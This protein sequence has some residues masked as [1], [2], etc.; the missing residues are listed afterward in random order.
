MLDILRGGATVQVALDRG[1]GQPYIPGQSVRAR[2]TVEC[3]RD[4][5]VREGRVALVYH[6]EY[7]YRH[8]ERGRDSQGHYHTSTHSTWATVEQE[9]VR[10]VFVH[11]GTIPAGSANAYEF[12]LPLPAEAAP[13]ARTPILRVQW[14]VK[15]TLDRRL[16]M[17]A[18]GKA[19]LPVISVAPAGAAPDAYYGASGEADQAELSFYLPGKVWALGEALTGQLVVRPRQEFDVTE[20]RVELVQRQMVPRALGNE[21]SEATPARVSDALRLTPGQDFS[22]PFS[23]VIP[24]AGPPSLAT[25]N[26]RS[27]WFLRGVLARRL[28]KDTAVEEEISICSARQ[29]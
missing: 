11:E 22:L 15:A 10:Q 23:L 18:E 16:A 25:P 5:T 27:Q 19:E 1:P 2:V 17:D 29:S 20:I 12:D 9:V 21:H 7:Q 14:L 8:E 26:G 24:P 4:L 13:S 6:E 3:P 28:R